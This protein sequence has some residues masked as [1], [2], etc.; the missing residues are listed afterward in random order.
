MATLNVATP[1]PALVAQMAKAERVVPAPWRAKCPRRLA[2]RRS[3]GSA[4][5][6]RRSS[7]RAALT[8]SADATR[9]HASALVIAC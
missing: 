9:G 7:E 5:K 3:Y 8:Q 1:R 4:Q 6:Q 2:W